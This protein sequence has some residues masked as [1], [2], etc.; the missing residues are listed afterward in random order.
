MI[1]V[2]RLP[3]VAACAAA[4][5]LLLLAPS[6]SHAA[7]TSTAT[8]TTATLTGTDVA[9]QVS[10]A[11]LGGLLMHDRSLKGDPGFNSAFDWASATPGDQTISATGGT[12]VTVVLNGGDDLLDAIAVTGGARIIADGGAGRDLLFGSV[13]ADALNGGSEDDRIVGGPGAD[14]L[15]GGAGDDTLVW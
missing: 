6:A 12:T 11:Q 13:A 8:A 7:F 9:E 1:T 14:A 3:T 10:I 2:I 4:M 15:S 5:A